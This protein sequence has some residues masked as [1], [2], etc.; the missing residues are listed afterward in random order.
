M[1]LIILILFFNLF[2][3]KLF[4][5][6]PNENYFNN[7]CNAELALCDSNWSSSLCFYKKAFNEKKLDSY[8]FDL[9][10]AIVCASLTN[11]VKDAK[12]FAKML[13]LK[14][15]DSAYFNK[16]CFEKLRTYKSWSRTIKSLPIKQP[17]KKNTNLATIIDSLYTK[18]QSRDENRKS[19]FSS[20][21]KFLKKEIEFNS[22]PSEAVI[23]IKIENNRFIDKTSFMLYHYKSYH[24]SD[25]IDS[26]LFI[27]VKKGDMHPVYFAWLP[28]KK[29][30]YNYSIKENN[31]LLVIGTEL[32]EANPRTA[33]L[34]EINKKRKE[35][36]LPEFDHF[37]KI[38]KFYLK[39][40]RFVY[41]VDGRIIIIESFADETSKERLLK[42]Y[43]LVGTYNTN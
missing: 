43:K 23:G 22:Y 2:V 13:I 7:I 41:P 19:Y 11:K 20:N 4:G 38:T 8:S 40:R 21:A 34:V 25:D 35:I 39:D 36:Y 24:R 12:K 28:F 5:Q 42:E 32:Y 1:K 29:A 30:I 27:S 16:K 15:C 14:G 9:H 31:A 10:N 18:D 26:L 33:H 17:N 3:Y 6:N 37:K